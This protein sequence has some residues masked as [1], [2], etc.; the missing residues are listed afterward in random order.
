MLIRIATSVVVPLGLAAIA[1]AQGPAATPWQGQA[2]PAVYQT[3]M[4]VTR[5]VTEPRTLYYKK[6]TNRSGVMPAAAAD[7]AAPL[8]AAQ[9]D[10]PPRQ[11]SNDSMSKP[12]DPEFVDPRKKAVDGIEPLF[13]LENEEQMVVRENARR[14]QEKD[15]NKNKERIVF[16]PHPLTGE[17]ATVR[18]FPAMQCLVEPN[19]VCYG[20]LYFE[21][22]NCERYGWE[23]GPLQPL[24][25]SAQF[26]S[27]VSN[28]P[29]RFFSYPRLRYD[30]SAG[31]CLPGDPVPYLLYPPGWSLTGF[32]GSIGVNAAIW[33]ILQ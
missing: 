31:Q 7:L 9:S 15:P 4:P 19:F 28:L 17:P 12:V 22:K 24:F 26:V 29:Y 18:P 6:D 3:P 33:G 14:A 5:P 2:R 23:M 1:V 20:R 32:A 30:C 11:Y 27:D 25:S 21:D 8:V 10:N 13:R 16:P